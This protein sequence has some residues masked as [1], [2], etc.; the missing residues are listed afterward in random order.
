MLALLTRAATGMFFYLQQDAEQCFAKD[1][2]QDTVLL[3]E[4][5][6]PGNPDSGNI[7][8]RVVSGDSLGS[9]GESGTPM[10]DKVLDGEDGRIVFTTETQGVHSI[11]FALVEGFDASGPDRHGQKVHFRLQ[12]GEVRLQSL[13][14]GR[15]DRKELRAEAL[16]CDIAV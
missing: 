5:Y 16:L 10:F 6:V 9:I 2:P 12:A 15:P 14:G 7:R 3:G 8:M 1:V 4:Y 11:C 13:A